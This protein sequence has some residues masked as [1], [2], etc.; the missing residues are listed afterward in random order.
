MLKIRLASLA[1]FLTFAPIWRA[2]TATPPKIDRVKWETFLRY[3]E[4]Y[5]SAVKF[6]F[7]DPKPSYIPGFYSVTV[8][9]SNGDSKL[10]RQYYVTA[11]GQSIISGTLWNINEG[12]FSETLKL[13]P[14]TG[15]SFGPADAPVNVVLFSD[16]QC[17]YCSQLAKTI[18]QELPKKYGDKVRVTFV[19]FP[20][21]AIHPW[22][23][24]AAESAQCLGVQNPAAFWV[25]HDW[26]FE[27][28][29][30]TTAANLRDETMTIAKQQSVDESKVAACL[31]SHA[32]AAQIDKDIQI[33]RAVQ[34]QQ[35]PTFFV[36]GR[37]ETGALPY[38][39]LA[40]LIEFELNR[41][42]E[43]STSSAASTEKC[44]E[45]NIPKVGGK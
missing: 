28:Q 1:L 19:D 22:A 27:H 41:P 16:F 20:L 2:A 31:D 29:K 15:F 39:R 38:D 3:A 21:S 36:N 7:E 18:R 42:K 10:D 13:L 32:P 37:T 45:V 4:G 6:E 24:A 12:P 25:F 40:A 43:F 23:R 9:L 33:G 44:C 34:V 8:H 17:P 5:V 26:I 11:D 14:K 35:T 30:E